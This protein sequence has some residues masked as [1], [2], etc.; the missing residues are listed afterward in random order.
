MKTIL[1]VEDEPSIADTLIHVLQSQG[2]KVY[3]EC[4]G[5]KAIEVINEHLLDLII[6]DI[7]LPDMN[8]FDVCKEIRASNQIP[9]IFLT[10]RAEEIDKVVGLEIGG[11]DY[12]TKPFSPR[13]VAAR[14]KAILKRSQPHNTNLTVSNEISL[15]ASG[16]DF[17]FNGKDFN[18][19]AIEF[20]LFEHL[21]SHANQVFSREQLLNACGQMADIGY[22]RNIDSHIKSIRSKVRKCHAEL[23]PIQTHRGFGYCFNQ[24]CHQ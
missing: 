20:K 24:K 5:S 1:I 18:F 19:T 2:F 23:D 11:D 13:E 17:S 9:I 3:W 21:Y 14:V 7:G 15:A 22:E 8:G 6:L 16:C 4:L 12:V 10:A